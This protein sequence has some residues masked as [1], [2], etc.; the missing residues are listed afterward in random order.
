[1]LTASGI[2]EN[3]AKTLKIKRIGENVE[4]LYMLVWLVKYFIYITVLGGL[5]VFNFGFTVVKESIDQ[6]LM[7]FYFPSFCRKPNG[8]FALDG[9]VA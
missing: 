6:E 4:C 3:R 8:N 9:L 1:M 5:V 7:C 2:S